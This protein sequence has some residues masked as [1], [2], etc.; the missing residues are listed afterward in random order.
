MNESIPI[1]SLSALRAAHTEMLRRR[2]SEG[3]T[4][5]FLEEVEGMIQAGRAAG[6]I[7]DNDAERETAQSL[8]DY[9]ST[10]MTQADRWDVD[11]TLD[12]FDP[13]LA[14]QLP[15]E[16][17]PYVGLAAFHDGRFFFG[18]E[19]L[20]VQ[21][22]E[23]LAEV[24]LVAVVGPSGSGKSSAVLAGLI[25]AL[26][27]GILPGSEGWRILPR[28]V[29]G[30][31]PLANLAR[32]LA[33]RDGSQS[34]T[35]ERGLSGMISQMLAD[36]GTLARLLGAGNGD[37]RPATLVIDQFEEAFTLCADDAERTAFVANL[38]GVVAV[39]DPP[40]RVILTMRSDF[41]SWVG[42]FPLLEAVFTQGRVQAT[43]LSAEEVRRAIEEPAALV[44]L[45]FQQGIVETLVSEVLG[46]PAALP[47]LQF[48]LAAL[49]DER[50]R[51][52]ITWE[53]YNRVG[54]G[55]TALARAADRLYHGLI[56]EEQR[57]ARRILLRMV[58]PGAGL[59]V[60]SNRI[61]VADLLALGEDPGRVGRV[62]DRLLAARLLKES[63]GDV[64]ADRQVEV[65]HE[66]LIRNWPTLVD[67]IEEERETLRHRRRLTDAAERWA[68][69][70]D[71]SLLW[72]GSQLAEAAAH[73]DLTPQ[74]QRFVAAS[75][76]AETRAQRRAQRNR[77]LQWA[78]LAVVFIAILAA[79]ATFGLSQRQLAQESRERS[80]EQAIANATIAAAATA[81]A[82]ARRG[83]EDA[84]QAAGLARA[85]AEAARQAARAGELAG[86][87]L[88]ELDLASDPS[89]SLALLL[90]R[91]AVL[92]TWRTEGT[93]TDAASLVLNL[94]V[95]NAPRWYRIAPDHPSANRI[96]ALAWSPDGNWVLSGSSDGAAQIWDAR[97]GKVL[98][99]IDAHSDQIRA[100][101]WSPD[102]SRILT[103]SHD[104]SA[105]VWSVESGRLLL[106]LSSENG[107]RGNV[108]SVDW[109][110]DGARI[111]TGGSDSIAIVWDATD[112]SFIRL[113]RG[114]T[115]WVRGVAW[116]PDNRQIVTASGD[117][118]AIIWEVSS[119]TPMRR[120][121]GHLSGLTSVDWSPDGRRVVTG[122]SGNSAKIWD[123]VTGTELVTLTGHSG[124]LTAVA[125]SMDGKFILTGSSDG[126]AR[127]WDSESGSQER[128]F[129]G[130]RDWVRSV[131]WNPEGT[132]F[133]T[134]SD[135]G[136]IRFWRLNEPSELVTLV[137]H[138]GQVMD[139]AW[140]PEGD[141]ILTGSADG[142]AKVWDSLNGTDLLTLQDHQD[143]VRAVEW[144]P[145]GQFV[146]TAGN[147][148]T[149]RIWDGRTG[150]Q[151]RE[152]RG[153]QGNIRD[154]A[155]SPDG[156]YIVT[157]SVDKTARI[158]DV[159]SGD[160]LH[161]FNE[162]TD[163]IYA[164][165]WSPDSTKIA[166]GGGD[167]IRIWDAISTLQVA[168]LGRGATSISW[169]PDSKFIVAGN[170]QTSEVE[171]WNTETGERLRV[172]RGHTN[173]VTST[174]WASDGQRILTGSSDGTAR[175]WDATSGAALFALIG[176]KGE[177]TS[178][179]WAPG[180]QRIITGSTDATARIWLD[181]EL[182]LE[183]ALSNVQR[184][185]P[186][187]TPEERIRYRIEDR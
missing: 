133:L 45:R 33:E 158:W 38:L 117:L 134:G 147:D 4:P 25:P 42:R 171:V 166:T 26:R 109:S 115:D 16:P 167:L 10:V 140:S 164:V 11:T 121:S 168:A 110:P 118:I 29:P 54:G 24:R 31:H 44:G 39:D 62:L 70:P 135:D 13:E 76:E 12:D 184:N 34:D 68:L 114:H 9:W 64:A 52:R 174:A 2:R 49:W 35:D 103:G 99:R 69:Q 88:A 163:A 180:G 87:A 20:V 183:V 149:A 53:V 15:D 46:E 32:L 36:A 155:W 84:A 144:S 40:H 125:W 78:A 123:A 67:W 101:A 1:P 14:P 21:M 157:V 94:A 108:I 154:V 111:V 59:E 175:I 169:S 126:T 63:E 98:L 119:G 96:N 130:H 122:S 170:W 19:R 47:L 141:R 56:P 55:R 61:P 95:K 77:R 104:G 80:Q 159:E 86:Q 51:N 73:V 132:H 178:V 131:A 102:S 145:N 143:W 74:E 152:I 156:R 138:D 136:F 89:G 100:V 120:L 128:V 160:Q 151:L 172:L 153:H 142:E 41:E 185:P 23:K 28:V 43:P 37:G 186:D 116:S 179:A 181:M 79:L 162:H 146:L 57:T 106:D 72:R 105:R 22:A 177:I 127:I 161:Q 48:T 150:R 92:T 7:L 66:A 148:D 85:T 165:S 182:L 176:H 173:L 3:E 93:A 50:Q 58:R 5:A 60:T 65:A 97:S 17:A 112:G 83:A 82:S 71:D 6:A 107:H 91:E 81:E 113:L 8:L 75:H 124:G 187:F 90:A 139:V 30:S 129:S 137:A 18:R 27:R